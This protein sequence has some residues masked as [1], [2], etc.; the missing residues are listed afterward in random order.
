MMAKI[1]RITYPYVYKI[2]QW[3]FPLNQNL[4]VSFVLL[5]FAIF[6]KRYSKKR[7]DGFE[8]LHFLK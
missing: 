7:S 6:Q 2:S 4:S 5:S 8:L 1:W 3:T